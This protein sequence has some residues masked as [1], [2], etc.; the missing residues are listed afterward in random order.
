LKKE[1]FKLLNI[2]IEEIEKQIGKFIKS[3]FSNVIYWLNRAFDDTAPL[4][5]D[6]VSTRNL[7]L[8]IKTSIDIYESNCDD[9]GLNP[10]EID[11]EDLNTL[12]EKLDTDFFISGNTLSKPLDKYDTQEI[13]EVI[14]RF[15]TGEYMTWKNKRISI[16]N[17]PFPMLV[18][19]KASPVDDDNFVNYQDINKAVGLSEKNYLYIF[20]QL[21]MQVD[22]LYKRCKALLQDEES[23]EEDIETL[24]AENEELKK[25]IESMKKNSSIK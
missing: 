15:S 6:E 1:F 25:Q 10:L 16:G 7:Y 22:V 2:P 17:D 3:F 11:S 18:N 24:V 13:D 19:Y 14:K 4:F 23:Y 8:L 21:Y 12:K 5:S 20:K 9:Y